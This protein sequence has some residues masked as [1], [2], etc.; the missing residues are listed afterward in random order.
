MALAKWSQKG[1]GS[2]ADEMRRRWRDVGCDRVG[3]ESRVVEPR[4]SERWNS[5]VALSPDS[6]YSHTWRWLDLLQKHICRETLFVALEEGSEFRAVFGGF[7]ESVRRPQVLR[8]L[9]LDKVLYS[10]HELTWDYGGPCFDFEVVEEE[11]LKFIRGIELAA[12]R[13]GSYSS[14]I[15]PFHPRVASLLAKLSYSERE[16][17]TSLLVLNPSEDTLWS[18]LRKS[19]RYSIRKAEHLDLRVTMGATRAGVAVVADYLQRL[20]TE[21]RFKI[22]PLSFFNDLFG[23]TDQLQPYWSIVRDASDE[24]LSVGIFLGHKGTMTYR[25]GASTE[26]GRRQCA[27][28]LQLW[29]S[30]LWAKTHGF[31]TLDLGGLPSDPTHGIYLFK[32]G[33]GGEIRHVDWYV[34]HLRYRKVLSTA[35]V[36]AQR[37]KNP[38]V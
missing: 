37:I 36:V 11:G 33:L 9:K 34:K 16:R 15:S 27:T 23:G 22:P 30:V 25:W 2:A 19:F 38:V 3:L 28:H 12:R 5:L 18:N 26:G 20:S 31:A 13:K 6:M 35:G 10:P 1:C 8:A 14:R 17:L 4:D 7:M 32:M 24:V 21:K 29:S